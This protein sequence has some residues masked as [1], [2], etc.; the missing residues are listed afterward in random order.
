MKVV[1]YFGALEPGLDYASSVR[2]MLA[3]LPAEYLHGL[4]AVVLRDKASLTRQERREGFGRADG[5]YV[6][7]RSGKL[8][9]RIELFLDNILAPIPRWLRWW[10][11]FLRE[12]VHGILLHEV[13][14]HLQATLIPQRGLPE[15]DA[16]ELAA[17]LWRRSFRQRHPVLTRLAGLA[18]WTRRML[19]RLRKLVTKAVT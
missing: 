14:H 15:E 1:E 16:W 19:L 7:S 6:R 5:D 8:P 13:G 18:F 3:T 12:T 2:R 10:P 4:E 11:L 9:P 17:R